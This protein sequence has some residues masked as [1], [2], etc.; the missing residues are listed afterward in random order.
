MKADWIVPM[1]AEQ[2]DLGFDSKLR[3]VEEQVHD[4][5]YRKRPWGLGMRPSKSTELVECSVCKKPGVFRVQRRT[6]D[7]KVGQVELHSFVHVVRIRASRAKAT[8]TPMRA[9]EVPR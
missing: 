8:T 6:F 3:K 2:V 4:V 7:P 9:C 1:E 5:D